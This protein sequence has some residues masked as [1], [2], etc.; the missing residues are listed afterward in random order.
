[1]I[2]GIKYIS[3]I[4]KS[5]KKLMHRFKVLVLDES[6]SSEYLSHISFLVFKTCVFFRKVIF[7]FVLFLILIVVV[8]LFLF[9]FRCTIFIYVLFI[10]YRTSGCIIYM[11]IPCSVFFRR[12]LISSLNITPTD[13]ETIHHICCF[14]C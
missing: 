5:R 12:F 7:L 14:W 11:N 9:I 2:Q 1:M 6:M 13:I 3:S 8:R 4:Y 10:K